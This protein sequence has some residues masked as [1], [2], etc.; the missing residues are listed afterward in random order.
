MW[1]HLCC[2]RG[3]DRFYNSPLNARE[4]LPDP[5]PEWQGAVMHKANPK[6]FHAGSD[7]EIGLPARRFYQPEG[8]GRPVQKGKDKSKLRDF[9]LLTSCLHLCF[10]P[11][12][13]DSTLH[14]WFSWRAPRAYPQ[15]GMIFCAVFEAV[16][17]ADSKLQ[18]I[19][20]HRG[21]VSTWPRESLAAAEDTSNVLQG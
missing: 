20:L 16:C 2:Y 1:L 18:P 17:F 4:G 8:A 19:S 7:L 3:A 5:R 15:H 10:G 21:R 14:F 12:I 6:C 11:C 9:H 13:V